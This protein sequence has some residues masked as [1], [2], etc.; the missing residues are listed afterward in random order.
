MKARG[1][2][3]TASAAAGRLSALE[4]KL[5]AD[6]ALLRARLEQ[7]APQLKAPPAAPPGDARIIRPAVV[8][9]QPAYPRLALI[10]SAAAA[11][12]LMLGVA[13][14]FVLETLHRARA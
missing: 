2:E 10:W 9:S 1:D 5:A 11:G 7:A 13:V 12:A 6:R 8:P 14:A 3:N 4:Q